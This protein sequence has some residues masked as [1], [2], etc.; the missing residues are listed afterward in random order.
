MSDNKSLIS[1]PD[2]SVFRDVQ[3]RFRTQ[4]LF[5]EYKY[6]EYPPIFTLSTE[7]KDGCISM[8]RKYIE[9]GDPT[10]YQVAMKLLGSWEHWELLS[11]RTWFK[12]HIDLWR[13]D[14]DRKRKSD[15]VFKVQDL[16]DN[17]SNEAV[18]SSAIKWLEERT[19]TQPKHS[20]KRGRPSKVEIENKLKDELDDLATINNDA[21]RL[22][23]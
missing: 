3:G 1:R 2:T 15:L 22:G 18:R 9:I 17:A 16:A 14:L 23:V 6:G 19:T 11:S 21:K 4:S 20:P 12:P 5:V 10:E 7:D 13:R 8:Y